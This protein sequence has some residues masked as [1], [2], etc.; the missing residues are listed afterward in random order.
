MTITSFV[1]FDLKKPISTSELKQNFHPLKWNSA[2][3]KMCIV[4]V[5]VIKKMLIYLADSLVKLHI[6]QIKNSLTH[7]LKKHHGREHS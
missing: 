5:Y 1:R 2:V 4:K 7:D 3:Q 6:F